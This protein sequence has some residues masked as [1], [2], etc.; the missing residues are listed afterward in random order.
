MAVPWYVNLTRAGPP[1]LAIFSYPQEFSC[2]SCS[3]AGVPTI[4]VDVQLVGDT[5]SKLFLL[6]GE[7]LTKL[8][9]GQQGFRCMLVAGNTSLEASFE[10]CKL[11]LEVLSECKGQVDAVL[12]SHLPLQEKCP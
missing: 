8:R 4:M 6:E 10:S 12:R 7:H 9:S 11:I 3:G 5:L 1:Q 2:S